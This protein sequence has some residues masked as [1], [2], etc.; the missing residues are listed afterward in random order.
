MHRVAPVLESKEPRMSF[1]LSLMN[2]DVFSEDRTRTIPVSKDPLN[3]QA[4]ETA[5]HNA[6]RARG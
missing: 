5:R 6:W 3:L 1:V 2:T 4:W